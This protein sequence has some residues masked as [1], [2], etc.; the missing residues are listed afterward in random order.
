[1]TTTDRYRE[2]D[3]AYVLGSLSPSE[4]REYEQ[5][6]ASCDTCAS[7]V[8]ALTGLAGP[9]S[10]L[11]PEKA[12]AL[13]DES[14][15]P[16]RPPD[17]LPQLLDVAERRQ[18]RSRRRAWWRT[19]GIAT[20]AAAAAAIVALAVPWGADTGTAPQ[21]PSMTAMRKVAPSPISAEARLVGGPWGTRIE[22]VC[23]YSGNS[24]DNAQLV[25]YL[26]YV[27]DTDGNKHQVGSWRAGPGMTYT[28]TGTTA[29][30]RTDIAQVEI[31][32]V[33]GDRKIKVLTL[34]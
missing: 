32:G 7:A 31:F 1:V 17:L 26:M 13:L 34:P 8:T 19:A 5:H 20:A 9:L 29:V 23:R 22:G 4:R 11:A 21:L 10:S 28:F 6:L 33:Y 14:A 3:A 25:E 15:Q 24:R 18:R 16:P 12:Y 2:W 27:T 30:P